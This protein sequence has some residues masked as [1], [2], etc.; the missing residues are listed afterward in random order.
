MKY[1]IV[2]IRDINKVRVIFEDEFLQNNEFYTQNILI[3]TLGLLFKDF[4]VDLMSRRE[5]GGK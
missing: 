2:N 1:I 5:K 4:S 3:E